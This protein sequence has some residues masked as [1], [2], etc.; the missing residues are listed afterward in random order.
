MRKVLIVAYNF[1]PINSPAALRVAGFARWLP[2][3]GWAPVVLA[4]A[5]GVGRAY[6]L[7]VPPGVEEWRVPDPDPVKAL[8]RRRQTGG[9]LPGAPGRS[10]RFWRA[11]Y[12]AAMFPDRDV[13][14]AMRAMRWARARLRGRPDVR[15]LVSSASGASKHWAA[16]WLRRRTGLPWVPVFHDPWAGDSL[17]DRPRT[18]LRRWVE[19]MFEA[20]LCRQADRIV[21]VSEGCVPRL[22]C[23]PEQVTVIRGGLEPDDYRHLP[24]APPAAPFRIAHAGNLYGGQRDPSGLLRAVAR[25]MDRGDLPRDGTE[26]LFIG[27][28]DPAVASLAAAA[29][30]SGVVRFTGPVPHRQALQ[31]LAASHV[32][33]VLT[34]PAGYELPIK[35]YEYL[36]V[37]RPILAVWDPAAELGRLVRAARAGQV[38]AP[39]DVAGIAGWLAG[40]YRA[41]QAGA[42]PA[43]P[44]PAALAGLTFRAASARL[45][46][47]LDAVASDPG[48]SSGQFA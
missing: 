29:G 17:A 28:A 32:L 5:G 37:G 42:P 47:L 13:L 15:A 6:D 14:W 21:T 39:D 1:P 7:P 2:E 45:A 20:A 34:T 9:G 31:W 25:L 35:L 23:P 46:E 41:W 8:V 30:L 11:V 48:T 40:Q 4:P 16:A 38:C 19:G 33:A 27:P 10:G 18:R 22:C 26:V 24:P 12:A 43:R 3:F 44:D 36:G